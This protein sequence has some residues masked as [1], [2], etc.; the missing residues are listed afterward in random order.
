[1]LSFTAEE[2]WRIV[3]PE[4]PTI[5]VQLFV[6][7]LPPVHDAAAL[8]RKWQRILTVRAAVLKELEAVRQSGAIGSSLQADVVYRASGALRDVL[9]GLGDE[10]KY[11]FITSKA[12][13]EAVAGEAGQGPVAT[14]DA[15]ASEAEQ[16]PVVMP[17]AA[18][19][20][21]RCWHYRADVGNDPSR[22]QLCGRCTDDADLCGGESRRV[23]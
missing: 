3:H 12:T 10:L 22:P 15:I 21:E 7:A 23:A 13:V 1:V 11:V 5:F 8:D 19:K 2:A 20:C 14:V 17:S 16:G 18:P 6:D 4:D 9:Q